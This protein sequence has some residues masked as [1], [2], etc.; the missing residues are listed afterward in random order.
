MKAKIMNKSKKQELNYTDKCDV[1]LINPPWLSKDD[2]IW[3]GVRSAM[4]PLGLLSIASWIESNGFKTKVMDIHVEGF[5]AE[6]VVDIISQ[7]QPKIVGFS[8]MTATSNAAHMAAKLVKKAAPDCITVFGGVHAE[9]LPIEVLCNKD[10]DI[11]VRGD[12]ELPF[13]E[14]CEGKDWSKI[15]GISY[16]KN[17]LVIHNPVGPVEMNLDIYPF[18][19]Y[20]LVP[21]EKYYPAIGAY[22]KLPGINMLM[23]RGCPGKCTFCNS[24]MT[25]LRTRSAKNMIEEIKWLYE[26]Y[27][28]REISFYDDTFTVMKKNVLE[29]CELMAKENMGITWSAFVRADCFNP[30]LAKAMKKAGCHQVLIG[31]ESGDMEILKLLRKPIDV[32]RTKKCIEIAREV[33]IDSR[34]AYIFGNQGETVDSMQNTLDF[35]IELDSDLAMYNVCTPYPGTQIYKWAKENNYL[36]SEEWGDFEYYTFMLKLPT[37]TEKEIME[38]YKNAHSKFFM[39]P[40]QFWRRLVRVTKISHIIDLIHAFFFIVLRI[41]TGSRVDT[42]DDWKNTKKTDFY[43]FT[44]TALDSTPALTYELREEDLAPEV[45]TTLVGSV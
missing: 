41:K 21:M 12:G 5:S 23:T 24:A 16:R 35:S 9:A 42:R 37:V 38:F 3:H 2:S 28:I 34:C 11:V 20:N 44:P 39:R 26:T 19:A 32:K 22:K 14:I 4:P 40:I 18:P 10:V 7:S 17:N 25:T 1:Y 33:G 27:G 15:K 30:I 6:N 8:V 29:F 43:D 45:T 13:L 36:K 31:V